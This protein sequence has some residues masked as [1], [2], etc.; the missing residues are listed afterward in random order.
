MNAKLL[1]KYLSGAEPNMRLIKNQVTTTLAFSLTSTK[2]H[3]FIE[4]QLDRIT[5]V[6]KVAPTTMNISSVAVHVPI[7]STVKI[8]SLAFT[9]VFTL[10]LTSSFVNIGGLNVIELAVVISPS[11]PGIS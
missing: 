5:W 3:D 1:A 6:N 9:L 4:Q 2:I 7:W 11:A 8:C 10:S